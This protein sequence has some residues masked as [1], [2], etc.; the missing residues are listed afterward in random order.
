MGGG[1]VK[2]GGRSGDYVLRYQV[3]YKIDFISERSLI[4][5]YFNVAQTDGSSLSALQIC[6]LVCLIR[7]Q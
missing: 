2:E 5:I 6:L 4:I 1:E 7:E 3:D